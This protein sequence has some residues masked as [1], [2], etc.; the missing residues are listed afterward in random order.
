MCKNN[1]Y[2][3]RTLKA[4]IFM[5]A[6]PMIQSPLQ[7]ISLED[8]D[9][10]ELKEL[11]R[12]R[13]KLVMQHTCL[14]MQLIS[15]IEQFFPKLQYFFNPNLHQKSVSVSDSS[16]SVQITHTIKQIKLLDSQLFTQRLK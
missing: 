4:T 16:L 5:I 6:P 14:K 7:F 3:T 2:K 10:I 11:D 13:L 1:I 9:Y 15:Y 8:L 12:F